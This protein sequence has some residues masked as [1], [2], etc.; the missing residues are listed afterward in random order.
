MNKEMSKWEKK[1]LQ[2]FR[3]F[4]FE[5]GLLMKRGF[6]LQCL[7]FFRV[8][9]IILFWMDYNKVIDQIIYY[10][11]LIFFPLP[12]MNGLQKMLFNL[13]FLHKYKH[14]HTTSIRS[15]SFCRF[16][17]KKNLLEKME[18]YEVKRHF[19]Y[20]G[21]TIFSSPHKFTKGCCLARM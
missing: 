16:L 4:V 14:I 5:V 6:S 1:N 17:N 2:N 9:I 19:V 12:T 8:K 21:N 10:P 7:Y 18:Q 11:I 20:I 15:S 13:F 3:L